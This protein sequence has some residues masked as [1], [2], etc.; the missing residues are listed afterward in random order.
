MAYLLGKGLLAPSALTCSCLLAPTLSSCPL[1]HLSPFPSPPLSMASAL[2]FAPFLCLYYPIKSPPHVLNKLFYTIPS[3][4]WS[5]RGE[6]CL[7]M[8]LLRYHLPDTSPHIH[9]NIF[10]LSLSSYKNIKND[11]RE[12]A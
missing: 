7:S 10:P 9:Q 3:H 6:R 12:V 1:P 4:G 5:L 8:G 2:S 11:L